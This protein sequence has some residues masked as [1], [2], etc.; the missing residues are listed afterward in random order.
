[1]RRRRRTKMNNLL[2]PMRG[3]SLFLRQAPRMPSRPARSSRLDDSDTD[4]LKRL[5]VWVMV[6]SALAGGTKPIASREQTSSILIQVTM[7]L[8]FWAER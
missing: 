7:Y 1:M 8:S 6:L 5:P 4:T 2:T 3:K